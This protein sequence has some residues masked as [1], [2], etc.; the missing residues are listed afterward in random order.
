LLIKTAA[1]KR[2][3]N[4]ICFLL[5]YIIIITIASFFLITK[6]KADIHIYLNQFHNRFFDCFFKNITYLGNGLFI[7]SV[8]IIL[9]M[10]SFRKSMFIITTY[11]TTG[12]LI[13]FLKRAVFY[14][15]DRPVE[16]FKG[17]LDLYLVEGVRIYY[18]FSFPSGHAAT[19]FG[20]FICIAFMSESKFIK[21]LCL[22]LACLVGYSRIY[23]S[24]HFLVD[25]YFGSLIGVVGG[26]FFYYIVYSGKAKWLDKSLLNL[27]RGKDEH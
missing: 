1:L 5:P 26:I 17:T 23:L 18:K 3:G 10:I 9:L 15:I 19:T 11:I 12:I 25:V 8:C 24:Q 13:Q 22:L 14:N 4:N 7:L 16:Y 20:F 27:K 2:I 21:L 6:S